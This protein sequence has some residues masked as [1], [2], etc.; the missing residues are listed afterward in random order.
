MKHGPGST[1]RPG[2]ESTRMHSIARNACN[3][4]PQPPPRCWCRVVLAADVRVGADDEAGERVVDGARPDMGEAR[5]SD[6]SWRGDVRRMQES[7]VAMARHARPL[8]SIQVR[9][10]S[11][12]IEESSWTEQ[13]ARL[14][15]AQASSAQRRG[16]TSSD[17]I[18]SKRGERLPARRCWS[19]ATRS[20]SRR[21][22]A[23]TDLCD[24]KAAGRRIRAARA[25]HHAA[26]AAQRPPSFASRH[27]RHR[28]RRRRRPL[29]A[30]AA[31]AEAEPLDGK[32]PAAAAAAAALAAAAVAAAARP[33][34]HV[35]RFAAS[36]SHLRL[37]LRRRPHGVPA[38]EM[39]TPRRR[40]RARARR[41]AHHV[42][43][44][45]RESSGGRRPAAGGRGVDG[46]G[47]CSLA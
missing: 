40:R 4:E 8:P 36:R 22:P 27:R 19:P 28:R 3:A 26:A 24:G 23:A 30:C 11:C 2:G 47:R 41:R 33:R 45:R 44:R 1:A 13:P 39:A 42:V 9:T 20:S 14:A 21:A 29:R 31:A 10:V 35:H 12:A 32:A 38:D 34:R 25:P 43:G 15:D 5:R 6:G 7:I 17:A 37:R 18:H 46:G 16:C